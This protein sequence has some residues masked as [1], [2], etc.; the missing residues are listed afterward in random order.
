M[1]TEVENY[2][3][4]PAGNVGP[5]FDNAMS[6]TMDGGMR[7]F[8]A[9][10]AEEGITGPTLMELMRQQARNFGTRIITQDIVEVDFDSHPFKVTIPRAIRTKAW[11]SL[12]QRGL[13]PIIW[14]FLRRTDSRTR[15]SAPV[16][17][18]MGRC[19]DF[20]TSLLW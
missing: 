5:Y 3:G 20:A 8:M 11:Q 2:P 15:A 18:A 17:C 13:G 1:T 10:S 12:W 16:R 14:D 9:E 4:Y 6:A 7:S 19:H